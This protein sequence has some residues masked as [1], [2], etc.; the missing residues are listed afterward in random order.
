LEERGVSD[1][2]PVKGFEDLWRPVARPRRIPDRGVLPTLPSSPMAVKARLARIAARA[3]EVMVKITGRTKG[4]GHLR[5]HL[6]YIARDG[7][8]PLEG[9]DGERLMA[10]EA[11]RERGADWAADDLK[12]R[13]DSSLSISIVLSMPA[14][15]PA[16]RMRD[17]ARAFA[18]EI[19]AERHDYVFALHTDA[20]H[21]HV[22]LAVRML[23]S[24]GVRLNPRKADLDAWR[25]SFARHLRAR[26]IAAEATPRRSRGVVHKAERMP[27]R[28]LRDRHERDPDRHPPSD[29]QAEAEREAARIA[30]GAR[31]ERP[32]E[33]K[34]LRQQR[35]VRGAYQAAADRLAGSGDAADRTL[36]AKLVD[37]LKTMPPIATRRNDLVRGERARGGSERPE[38][39]RNWP[40]QDGRGRDRKR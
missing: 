14:G 16:G 10:R 4:A 9:R 34:I 29:R 38:P 11:I 20:G 5:A 26:D 6:E 25:Q 1:F 2:E 40:D 23:G 31:I 37:F 35:R 18:A 7:A 19:F 8:L 15:T 39:D 30:S 24:G 17:A 12:A 36:A 21:P 33:A 22:H 3:P 13:G 27:L 32:W 28:K